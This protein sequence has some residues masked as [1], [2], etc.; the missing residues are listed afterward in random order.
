MHLIYSLFII[1]SNYSILFYFFVAGGCEAS[2]VC[3]TS[4]AGPGRFLPFSSRYALTLRASF[5]MSRM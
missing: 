5:S 4:S 2:P 3:G 1:V